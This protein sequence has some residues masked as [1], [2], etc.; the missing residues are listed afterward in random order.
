MRNLYMYVCTYVYMKQ[1]LP[2]SSVFCFVFGNNP[3]WGNDKINNFSVS[4][5]AS[6]QV[7]ELFFVHVINLPEVGELGRVRS[8]FSSSGNYTPL[9]D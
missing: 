9:M 8:L 5:K 6:F 2:L 7:E 3:L 4:S 1:H